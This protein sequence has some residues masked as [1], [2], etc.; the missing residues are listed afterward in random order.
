MIPRAEPVAPSQ[1]DPGQAAA[2]PT[3][4]EIGS[5][6][7]VRKFAEQI[8][9]KNAAGSPANED[10]SLVAIDWEAV[11]AAVAEARTLEQAV[12]RA[13]VIADQMSRGLRDDYRLQVLPSWP[14][15]EDPFFAF[16]M[17]DVVPDFGDGSR[18]RSKVRKKVA[19]IFGNR[20]A[21]LV[22]G[23]AQAGTSPSPAMTEDDRGR[24]AG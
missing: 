23:F 22:T 6:D 8:L 3:A 24:L 16:S 20:R 9:E 17:A 4:F 2:F 11:E 1:T 12:G 21:D 19:K 5:F 13:V 18:Y 15:G 14:K 7:L 10:R